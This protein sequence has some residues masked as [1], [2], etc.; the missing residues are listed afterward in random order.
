MCRLF[1]LIA[2]KE[3][4][5]NYSFSEA[6][7]RPFKELSKHNKDGWGVGWYEDGEARMFK[8]GLDEAGSG[9]DYR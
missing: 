1:G 8:E 7:E 2:N 5:M 4:D 3:A 6:E 9:D